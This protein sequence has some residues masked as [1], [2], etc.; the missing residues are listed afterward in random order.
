MTFVSLSCF[1]C[2]HVCNTQYVLLLLAV[3]FAIY[4]GLLL[5]ITVFCVITSFSLTCYFYPP[6]VLHLYHLFLYLSFCLVNLYQLILLFLSVSL[7]TSLSLSRYFCQSILLLLPVFLVTCT[8][9]SIN[10]YSV[11]LSCYFCQSH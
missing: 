5:V 1:V 10:C 7:V 3:F 9:V 2:H 4:V 8:S 11:S 6:F